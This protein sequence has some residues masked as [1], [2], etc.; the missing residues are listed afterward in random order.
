MRVTPENFVKVGLMA[1]VFLAVARMLSARL[2]LPGL[3]DLV[4]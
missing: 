4:D 1:M 3:A 2:G